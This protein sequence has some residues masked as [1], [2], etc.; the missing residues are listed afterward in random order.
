VIVHRFRVSTEPVR[1]T[2]VT[3]RDFSTTLHDGWRGVGRVRDGYRRIH[4]YWPG[5]EA[6]LLG[7]GTARTRLAALVAAGLSGEDAGEVLGRV[8]V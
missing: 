8:G 4:V 7:Y 1:S 3:G 5:R 2:A 6:R